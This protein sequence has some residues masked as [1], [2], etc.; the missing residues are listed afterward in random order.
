MAS[1]T[2]PKLPFVGSN[3]ITRSFLFNSGRRDQRVEKLD[4]LTKFL[5]FVNSNDTV[6]VSIAALGSLFAKKFKSWV[7]YC[8]IAGL[9]LLSPFVLLSV[10]GWILDGFPIENLGNHIYFILIGLVV[11]GVRF[12]HVVLYGGV[13]RLIVFCITWFIRKFQ[14]K[15]LLPVDE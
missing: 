3:P 14:K 7:F 2:L 8:V 1:L 9:L 11:T 4:F 15:T 13:L 5:E 10:L 6:I 12:F